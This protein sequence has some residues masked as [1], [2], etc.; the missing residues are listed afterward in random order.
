MR[1]LRLIGAVL[2]IAALA[3]GVVWASIDDTARPPVPGQHGDP[4][5]PSS[6]PQPVG[7]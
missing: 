5:D 7:S 4:G 2:L 1:W 6:Y 3:A